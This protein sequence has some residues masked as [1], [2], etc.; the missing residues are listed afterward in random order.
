MTKRNI[1]IGRA[2]LLSLLAISG[3]FWLK[4][5]PNVFAQGAGAEWETL[6]QKVMDLYRTGNYDRAVTVAKKALEVAEKNAGP[7]HPDV[8]TSL[9]NLALLYYT[10]GHYGQSEPLS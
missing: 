7:D 8:A 1:R 3:F 10:E 6:N 9:N 4:P 2:V 5:K